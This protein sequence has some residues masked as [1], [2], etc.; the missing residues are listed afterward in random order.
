MRYSVKPAGAGGERDG[1]SCPS[2]ARP[3]GSAYFD[4]GV[5]D[6]VQ[7]FGFRGKHTWHMPSSES[8]SNA[9][10]RKRLKHAALIK[11]THSMQP[12]SST[13]TAC[14]LHYAHTARSLH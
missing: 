5:G 11:H 9:L 1:K 3:H 10:A 8:C 14:S 7:G 12:S 4:R 6:D 13:R 2:H